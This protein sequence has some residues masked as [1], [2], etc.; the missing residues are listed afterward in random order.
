MT[1]QAIR[2]LFEPG[3]IAFAPGARGDTAAERVLRENLTAPGLA[4]PVEVLAHRIPRD[5]GFDLAVIAL[6]N[7]NA[8]RALE[9]LA[10]HGARAVVFVDTGMRR[11]AD[12]AREA[13]ELRTL[14][15][16]LGL[17]ALGPSRGG[18][19]VPGLG[20]SAGTVSDIPAA[21]SLAFVTQSDSVLG[22]ILDRAAARGVGFS[23]V[24][25]VGKSGDVVLGDLLDYLALDERT[26]AVL[27]HL[28]HVAD[29]RRFVSAARALAWSKPV[30]VLRAGRSR[31]R[32]AD[33][34]SPLGRVMRRD[35]VYDAVF[36]RAGLVR[37][38]SID[39]LFDAALALERFGAGHLRDLT[40]GRLAILGNGTGA[41]LLA[42][43]A[44]V[45]GG[46]TLALLDERTRSALAGAPRE[47]ECCIDLG[48]EANADRFAVA[49]T[50]VL[51]GGECDGA[52]V[53]FTPVPG[54]E[55]AAVAAALADAARRSDGALVIA[56][57][58][59]ATG[60]A[61]AQAALE[62]A[63]IPVYRDAVEA[64]TAFLAG[65]RA[66]R[67]RAQ[68][69]QIPVA[70]TGD[71]PRVAEATAAIEA[72]LARGQDGIRGEDFLGLIG[73]YEI[74]TAVVRRA[75]TTAE[76]RS[77]AR[78]VGFPVTVGGLVRGGGQRS[79]RLAPVA[80]DDAADLV[81]CCRALRDRARRMHKD[82]RLAA[83]LVSA[84]PRSED[85]VA[86][87]V[88]MVTDTLFGP[89]MIVGQGGPHFA[90]M[91]DFVCA[92]PPLDAALA[93]ATLGATRI[94]R[95]VLATTGRSPANADA[96]IG[97][98]VQLSQLVADQAAI[99]EMI[100]NPL[101]AGRDG[102]LAMGGELRLAKSRRGARGAERLAIRPYPKALEQAVRL[103]D[104][105][106][107]RMRPIR[108]EDARAM[109]SA[110]LRMTPEDRRMRLFT[111]TSVL[112]DDL[113]ARHTAIDYDREMALVIED[114]GHPGELW[115]GARIVADPD[116]S[117]AEYAVSTRS[118][119]QRRG[120]GE[121]ALRA[122][123]AY[124]AERG[125]RTVRGSVLRE[126]AAMRGLAKRI[127]FRETRDPDD[128]ACV[129]TL[130][131]PASPAAP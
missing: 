85:S 45:A 62:A 64:V 128:P 112:R 12:T 70:T 48:A 50:A 86:L 103:R 99:V 40:R 95:L 123:L 63:R 8:Q 118:D 56:A 61:D 67:A 47:R 44:L 83:F 79:V 108:P 36:R 77:A 122:I 71:V 20:L 102:V 98:L 37:V 41:A 23:K 80:A 94:G 125:I 129:L 35:D 22:A 19:I 106:N 25:S 73:A 46:G 53:I 78:A 121:T 109:Q 81:R 110:F 30:L 107:V 13:Q 105:T 15:R 32:P 52:L 101:L 87:I 17:R 34:K 76:V 130:I 42:A 59:G 104:G 21:G 29:P 69:A 9:R 11:A 5:A 66:G 49:L 119:V 2:A 38:P 10:R 14:A 84:Q 7:A 54:V 68:L 88:G 55:P 18:V 90:A 4:V 100:V 28:E 116:G 92:L 124:A 24:A 120:I 1:V 6:P 39:A 127:G 3:R 97:A 65:M 115:G 16:E 43:D 89:V 93:R 131:D 91:D 113:A 27:V 31:E 58:L 82:A 74:G 114:P 60:L 72:A 117:T 96:V 26:S 33:T 57:W 75:R 126:N 111:P 51:A